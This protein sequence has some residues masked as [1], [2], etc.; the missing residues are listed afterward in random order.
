MKKLLI[1]CLFAFNVSLF[2]QSNFNNSSILAYRQAVSNYEAKEYGKALKYA[3]DAITYRKLQIEKEVDFFETSLAS[4]DVKKAGDKITSILPVLEDRGEKDCIALI[5]YYELKKGENFFNNSIT[6]LVNYIDG[7]KYYPEAQKL[8]GDIYKIEGEYSFAEEYYLKALEHKDVLDIPDEQY[9]ILY[10]LAELSRLQQDF[11]KMEIRLL[12]IIDK[13]QVEKNTVLTRSIKSLM[14]QKKTKDKINKLFTMYRSEGF[15]YLDAYS[16]LAEY[17]YDN[18][19]YEKAFNYSSL[20]VITGYSKIYNILVKREMD[21]EYTTLED[22]LQKVVYHPDMVEWGRDKKVWKSFNYFCKVCD[23]MG[24]N[25]FSFDLLV[26]LAK[27]SPEPYWQQ[28]AV[29]QLDTI[30]GIKN[31]D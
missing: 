4:K 22:F 9:E 16:Q 20:A 29:L 14:N 19:Q 6:Q 18:E 13:Q 26:I 8:I 2:A 23:K 11:S 17:Y 21:Y 27:N 3:E 12:N 1:F 31:P 5:K 10:S 7:Q 15:M 24:W 25:K 30:D 28:E